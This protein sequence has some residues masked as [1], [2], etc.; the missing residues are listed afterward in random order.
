VYCVLIGATVL[1]INF[2][3]KFVPDKFGIELG[4]KERSIDDGGF[5]HT[6]RS[7]RTVTLTKKATA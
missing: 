6:F 1:P 4:K 7:A 3:I 5:I 2:F